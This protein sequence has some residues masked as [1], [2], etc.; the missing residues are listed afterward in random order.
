MSASYLWLGRLQ[1]S[2]T[3]LSRL[4]WSRVKERGKKFLCVAVI[5]NLAGMAFSFVLYKS[6]V[7]NLSIALVSMIGAVFH[8]LITYSSHYFITF[9]IPGGFFMGLCRVYPTAWVGMLV[10]SLLGQFLIGT[11]GFNYIPAQVLIFCF[12]A[13]YSILVSFLFIYRQKSSDAPMPSEPTIETG[14]VK[15]H[16]SNPPVP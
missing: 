13:T 9:G 15:T 6:L 12:C 5:S 4:L 2:L 14:T 10:A 11:L 16:H 3:D 8:V 1:N 7:P